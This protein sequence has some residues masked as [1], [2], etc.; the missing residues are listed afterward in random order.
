MW[1]PVKLCPPPLLALPR[2]IWFWKNQKP[3]WASPLLSKRSIPKKICLH[4]VA[5]TEPGQL[6]LGDVVYS[7]AKPF[8]KMSL[9][10]RPPVAWFQ[11]ELEYRCVEGERRERD[12]HGH[13][14]RDHS[15]E[16]Q[17][18]PAPE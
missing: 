9:P 4:V 16:R 17:I 2:L 10:G 18:A 11:A 12:D 13:R 15:R 5:A 3:F 8:S 6:A 1:T 7:A 14:R